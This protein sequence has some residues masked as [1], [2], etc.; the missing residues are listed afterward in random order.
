MEF[1][2]EASAASE[3]PMTLLFPFK[4]EELR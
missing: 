4:T 2:H 1:E 3:T